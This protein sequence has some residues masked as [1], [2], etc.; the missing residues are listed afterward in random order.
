MLNSSGDLANEKIETNYDWPTE[1]DLTNLGK[2][3]KE[4]RKKKKTGP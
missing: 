4:K 1:G 3:K 2:S